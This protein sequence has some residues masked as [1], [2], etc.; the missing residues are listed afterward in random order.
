MIC[1]FFEIDWV[2]VEENGAAE[3]SGRLSIQTHDCA[4]MVVSSSHIRGNPNAM[5]SLHAV[6]AGL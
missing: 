4:T 6:G 3:G 2:L 5:Y 1:A